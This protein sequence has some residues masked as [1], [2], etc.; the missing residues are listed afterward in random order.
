MGLPGKWGSAFRLRDKHPKICRGGFKP[1]P[2]PSSLQARPAPEFWE[3]QNGPGGKDEESGLGTAGSPATRTCL[4]QGRLVNSTHHEAEIASR[5]SREA[6]REAGRPLRL[7]PH[8]LLSPGAR[9][10][11]RRACG[12]DPGLEESLRGLGRGCSV[13]GRGALLRDR[14]GSREVLGQR[15]HPGPGS[16]AEELEQGVRGL[17]S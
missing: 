5:R 11:R 7:P 6:G 4:V 15:R 17:G 13:S 9:G 3:V 14:T 1:S 2:L 10:R 16:V 8:P 12:R